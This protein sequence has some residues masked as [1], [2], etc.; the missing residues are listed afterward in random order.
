MVIPKS[1]KYL[2][3]LFVAVT[4]VVTGSFVLH[5]LEVKRNLAKE[6]KSTLDFM[7]A[8]VSLCILLPGIAFMII[9]ILK[10]ICALT[11]YAPICAIS[12]EFKHGAGTKLLKDM[13]IGG[14]T[15]IFKSSA[16]AGS[17]TK[18]LTPSPVQSDIESNISTNSETTTINEGI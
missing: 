11:N 4:L 2:L 5:W 10:L 18:A 17:L 3:F 13:K 6:P 12:G 1:L 14:L 15:N 7:K 8:A 9:Y 16:K